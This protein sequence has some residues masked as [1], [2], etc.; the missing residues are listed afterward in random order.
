MCVCVRDEGDVGRL[1]IDRIHDR[2]LG[3]RYKIVLGEV[4]V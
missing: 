4:G 2:L 3:A 1:R